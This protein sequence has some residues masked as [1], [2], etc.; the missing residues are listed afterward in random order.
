MLVPQEIIDFTKDNPNILCNLGPE[1]RPLPIVKGLVLDLDIA[2]NRIWVYEPVMDFLKTIKE[3]ERVLILLN[4]LDNKTKTGV[5]DIEQVFWDGCGYPR[6][7]FDW[8]E[9]EWK[10]HLWGAFIMAIA[11][12]KPDTKIFLRKDPQFKIFKKLIERDI[13]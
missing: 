1:Q 11:R 3:R 7:D 9:G 10:F 5:L 6:L 13:F 4:A 12:V 2:T 8:K